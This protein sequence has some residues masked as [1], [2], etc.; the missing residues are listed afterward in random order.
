[1]R[2]KQGRGRDIKGKKMDSVGTV[3]GGERKGRKGK[4]VKRQDVHEAETKGRRWCKGGRW[5]GAL[6]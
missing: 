5:A 6:R 1:M 3:W 2:G 4:Q